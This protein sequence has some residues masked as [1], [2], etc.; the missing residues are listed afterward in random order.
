[1]GGT[2]GSYTLTYTATGLTDATQSI[3]L[4]HGTATTLELVAPSTADNARVISSDVV[5]RLKDADGN[6]VTTGTPQVT[7]SI[8]G[9]TISGTAVRNLASGEVSFPG[10]KFI[11]TTGS[12]TLS[13]AITSPVSLT[14]TSPVQL[15]FGD[16]TK[17][18]VTT[19]ASGAV[20]RQLFTTQP[21][22][23]VQDVSG[24][25]VTSFSGTI[26]LSVS[27]ADAALSGTTS[28]VLSGSAVAYFDGLALNGKV[29]SYTLTFESSGLTADSQ[30]ITVAHGTATSL[31]VAVTSSAVNNQTISDVVV[32]V[33]DEDSNLIT[34]GAPSIS[35]AGSSSELTG[36]LVRNASSGIA[37]FPGLKFVGLTGG[38]NV[39]A[40]ASSLS[41]TS[42]GNIV[43]VSHGAATQM[44]LSTPASSAVNRAGIT[45]VPVVTFKD[46]SGN[47]VENASATVTVSESSNAVALSGTA[48]RTPTS[49]V[50]TFSGLGLNGTVGS[51]TLTYSSAGLADLTQT[52][53]L[54][55]G[56]ATKLDIVATAATSRSGQVFGA[57]PAVRILDQDNNLV[58]TGASSTATITAALT[59]LSDPAPVTLN[60][61][62]LVAAVGGELTF[63]G[64]GLTGT[65][66]NYTIQYSSPNIA[67]ASQSIALLAG[68][69][70][71]INIITGPA[72][73]IAGAGFGS[74]VSV[75]LR[76][77]SNNRVL[78]DSTTDITATLVSSSDVSTRT[79]STTT[80]RVTNGLATFTGLNYTLAGDHKISFV[81]GGLNKISSSFT[82]THAIASKFTI[83]TQ[84]AA[85]RNDIVVGVAPA[86]RIFDAYDNPVLSGS[87]VSVTASVVGSNSSDISSI[88]GNTTSSIAN[89][90]LVSLPNLKLKGKVSNY[91]I[92]F[93]GSVSGTSL[94]VD[95]N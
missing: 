3:A 76:D 75:E 91:V 57:Q 58:S 41:L 6:L 59:G 19:Q 16:A 64:L 29:G 95:S 84:P 34:T 66:G 14:T 54:T 69:P 68:T 93:T 88:S 20:N 43:T 35:L 37:N 32:R 92:R 4:A 11:G 1:L 83:E 42:A 13:A 71:A 8:S 26:N 10:L 81:G 73:A 60:G 23:T 90:N 48:S 61:T 27:P 74:T 17:L 89:T 80:V 82:I 5:V 87:A 62:A 52:I 39:V 31:S 33:L 7:L 46:I 53:D 50:V 36:T 15:S 40:T 44:V 30:A 21:A 56:A 47:T 55:H 49:G 63:A 79:V 12:K 2:L 22:V 9:A 18:V 25:P 94:T 65:A 78:S 70:S 28:R 24:N 77:A 85:M 67:S 72:D 38:K 51:Y 45:T 86:L